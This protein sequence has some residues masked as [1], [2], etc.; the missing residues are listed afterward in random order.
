MNRLLL[1]TLLS[2]LLTAC[3]VTER[4]TY[5][6][7]TWTGDARLPDTTY[8][9]P[10]TKPAEEPMADDEADVYEEPAYEPPADDPPPRR[11]WEEDLDALGEPEPVT[12]TPY[13]AESALALRDVYP[14]RSASAL[15][16]SLTGENKPGGV[17]LRFRRIVPENTPRYV[18]RDFEDLPLFIADETPDGWLAFYKGDC[19]ELGT[20]CRYHTIFY[21]VTGTRR[22]SFGLNPFLS[23]ERQVEIQ[24]IR[25]HKGKVYFNEACAT[26]S[27]EANGECSALVRLDPEWQEVDWRTPPLTSNNIFILSDP[28]V[29]AGY[30]FTSE[31]DFIYL[32]DQSTGSIV[33]T[34]ELDS[35]HEYMEIVNGR[36]VVVTYSNVYTFELE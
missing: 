31:P 18:P 10:R 29:I 17:S 21:D 6:S 12:D 24:D 32:I 27:S 7:I 20:V 15:P 11:P 2:L 36:L 28:Y 33:A 19:G 35:A 22:W 13:A 30:G 25:Y 34:A 5:P 3:S 14:R 4:G 16:R 9:T 26:Y 1:F 23:Q 8:A